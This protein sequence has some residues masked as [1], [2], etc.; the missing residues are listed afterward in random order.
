MKRFLYPC[1]IALALF[2]F[3]FYRVD[4]FSA[5]KIHGS[6]LE[7]GVEP[8]SSQVL[9]NQP[10]RYL[11][12]GRQCFAFVSEDGKTVIKFLNYDRF[13]FTKRRR[14]RF[15]TTLSSLQLAWEFLREETGLLYL[16]LQRGGAL[17]SIELIDRGHR[18]HRIDLNQVVFVLQKRATPIQEEFERRG[19]EPSIDA[20]LSIV[21]KRC[22]QG[23][24]DDDYDLWI[25]FGFVE[26]RLILFDPGRLSLSDALKTPEG[27]A[28][29]IRIATKR[30]RKWLLAKHPEEVAYLDAQCN[31]AITLLSE[32][33]TAEAR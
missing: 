2:G 32:E 15:Q 28:K 21:R 5:A 4:G 17:P 31:N 1:F 29:E 12:K 25:N 27:I 20:L 24:T 14:D 3:A 6:C 11:A 10:F 22:E 8:I 18:R 30:L 13:S 33:T 9:L 16:H 26:D 23:I 7:G 19:I